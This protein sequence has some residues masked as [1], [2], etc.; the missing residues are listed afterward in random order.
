MILEHNITDKALHPITERREPNDRV[1]L[2]VSR[3]PKHII[4]T[5]YGPPRFCNCK[6]WK[7]LLQRNEI[8]VR[9]QAATVTPGD[10]MLRRLKFPLWFPL[11]LFMGLRRKKIP[12]HELA[13]RDP[14]RWRRC[15]AFPARRPG[16]WHH[17][18]AE[19]WRQCR[20]CLSARSMG[21]RGPATKPANMTYEEAAAVPVG[22]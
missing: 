18:R 15:K 17:H 7:N 13:G 5:A 19:R 3:P 10:V 9:V 22:A 4:C 16:L 8:A 14:S 20:V 11:R 21:H 2:V 6:T 12:G 1:Q